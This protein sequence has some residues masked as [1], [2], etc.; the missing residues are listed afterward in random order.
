VSTEDDET[1]ER[2]TEGD[3]APSERETTEDDSTTEAET[4]ED[5]STTEAETTEDDSTTE[6]ETTGDDPVPRH[7]L[8]I[9]IGSLTGAIAW[10]LIP[11]FGVGTVYAGYKLYD[12][13]SK[14]ISGGIFVVL[15]VLPLVFWVLF[16]VQTA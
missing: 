5:D 8:Y 3:P 14:T 15:G 10:L 12:S 2:A 13:E 6:A 9:G 11:L 16:L 4:T 1:D 7:W